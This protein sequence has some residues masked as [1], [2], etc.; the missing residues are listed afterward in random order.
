MEASFAAVTPRPLRLRTDQAHA[1]TAGVVVDPPGGG[2]EFVDVARRE[3][4]GRGMRA[5]RDFDLPFVRNGGD[6][7]R[8][9]L[10]VLRSFANMQDIA[11][12]KG[13]TRMTSKLAQSEGAGAPQ[14]QRHIET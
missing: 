1:G 5:V 11:G 2:K 7:D 12:A 6:G 3:E 9:R 13:A 10:E 4:I 14:I 8:C